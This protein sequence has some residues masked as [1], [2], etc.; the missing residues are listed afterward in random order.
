M[1]C[2]SNG[3][4]AEPQFA[5]VSYIPDPLG[6]F[7]DDLRREMVPE[8][9]PKAHVTILPP[10]PVIGKPSVAAEQMERLTR[11]FLSFEVELGEIDKFE[12]SDVIYVG[13]TRGQEELRSMY[14]ALNRGPVEFKEKYEYHPH[15]TLAQYIPRDD[16][17]RLH[18]LAR[19][20]WAEYRGS[21]SFPVDILAFVRNSGG[22]LWDDLA[23]ISLLVPTQIS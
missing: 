1:G 19:R 12:A 11:N 13:V 16:V 18:E 2:I 22:T 3:S 14:R 15:I 23:N 17:S 5:L 4:T 6:I 20:R 21:R 7:L 10:R 8:C 9:Q